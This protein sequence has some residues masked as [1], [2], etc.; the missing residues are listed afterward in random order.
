M[1]DQTTSSVG[2]FFLMFKSLIENLLN[3]RYVLQL[4]RLKNVIQYYDSV[5]GKM[6]TESISF[7]IRITDHFEC[8]YSG[9]RCFK[10]LLIFKRS[11]TKLTIV[12]ANKN[13]MCNKNG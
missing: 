8:K 7:K 10:R 12:K 13:Y 4:R 3:I 9:L 6:K 2:N 11:I 1:K 5:T